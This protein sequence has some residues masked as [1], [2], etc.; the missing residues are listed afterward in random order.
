MSRFA[1]I[2]KMQILLASAT[3]AEIEISA[4]WL[5]KKNYRIGNCEFKTLITGVGLVPT[6][7]A[8]INH[9]SSHQ[10]GCIIQAGIAGAFDAGVEGRVY[11]IKEDG[12]GDWGVIENGEFKTVFDIKLLKE[13]EAPFVGGRLQNPNYSLLELS[14]LEQASAV[15]VNEITTDN[16]RIHWIQQN[17]PRLVESMEGAAF[18]YVC[19]LKEIPFI[20]FRSVSNLIGQRDK[21]K[22]KMGEAIQNLNHS[23]ISFL[24]ILSS[25]HETHFGF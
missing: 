22:W 21:T 25:Q 5:K 9:L 7:F 11:V 20:Q 1:D 12:F 18:H 4:E 24:E 13:D 2:C 14:S 8:L 19:L 6:T 17:H 16:D 3:S 10:P 15:S 23:L